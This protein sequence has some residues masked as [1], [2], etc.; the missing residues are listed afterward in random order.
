MNY[1]WRIE[2]EIQSPDI[3]H[4]LLT[5]RLTPLPLPHQQPLV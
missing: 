3:H 5:I 2:D 1:K 4:S